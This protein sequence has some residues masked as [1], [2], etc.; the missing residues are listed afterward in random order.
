M[1]GYYKEPQLTAAMFDDDGYLKTGDIGEFDH[2]GY[3]TITG[4]IKDQFKTDKGKYI[5]P[6]PIEVECMKNSDIDQICI[7]GTGIPQPIALIVL[8]DSGKMKSREELK[9]S[10]AQM[11]ESINGTLENHEKIEKAVIMKESWSIDNGLL[12]PTF[13]VKRTQIEK[14]H[15][16]FYPIWFHKD[17]KVIFEAPNT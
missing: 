4:R 15:H 8:S 13:K 12:T 16:A 5:A 11:M 1:K 2:D 9:I 7:V 14:I 17:E 3:L 6:A 10:F